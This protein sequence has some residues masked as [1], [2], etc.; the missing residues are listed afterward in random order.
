MSV[1]R[2]ISVRTS[3][4]P[5]AIAS[6]AI[7]SHRRDTTEILLKANHTNHTHTRARALISTGKVLEFLAR[8]PGFDTSLVNDVHV[9]PTLI[10]LQYDK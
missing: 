6:D 2:C 9:P 7:S 1:A 3:Y 5:S 4:N 10:S 8:G